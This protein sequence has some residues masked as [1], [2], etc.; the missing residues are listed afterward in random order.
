[1]T[2]NTNIY[3]NDDKVKKITVFGSFLEAVIF[4]FSNLSSCIVRSLPYVILTSLLY[5]VPRSFDINIETFSLVVSP[6]LYATFAVSWHRF[7]IYGANE[8]KSTFPVEFGVREIKFGA[9]GLIIT[10]ITQALTL[11][12]FGADPAAFASY[13]SASNMF[14]FFLLTSIIGLSTFLIFPAIALKQP[15]EVVLLFK[16]GVKMTGSFI[17]FFLVIGFVTTMFNLFLGVISTTNIAYE[18]A[19]QSEG[20]Q[21]FINFVIL[22]PLSLAITVST[23]TFLYRDLIG[24][25]ETTAIEN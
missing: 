17:L 14:I 24:I 8:N 19:M 2:E 16:K 6:F 25:K 4:V 1:M 13:V 12:Y 7:S 15:I 5:F 11:K 10:T 23:V 3:K 18:L 21:Y 22:S 20:V 9:V